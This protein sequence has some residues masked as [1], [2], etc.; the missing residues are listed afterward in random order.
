[1]GVYGNLWR[2]FSQNGGF[3]VDKWQRMV[4]IGKVVTY[5]KTRHFRR[6]SLV[7][8]DDNSDRQNCNRVPPKPKVT[9]S[10]PAEDNG[11]ES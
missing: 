5:W 11:R 2:L 7:L 8:F 9:G 1:V 10:S 3:P 6:F 4:I